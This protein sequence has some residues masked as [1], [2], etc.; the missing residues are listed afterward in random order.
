MV[1][2]KTMLS[3]LNTMKTES[4]SNRYGQVKIDD[5]LALVV[6]KTIIGEAVLR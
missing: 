4:N 1:T 2:M 5:F 6:S 3:L